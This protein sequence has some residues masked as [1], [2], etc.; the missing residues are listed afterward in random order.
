LL[1]NGWYEDRQSAWLR[2]GASQIHQ[3]L[4]NPWNWELTSLAQSIHWIV[5]EKRKM[6]FYAR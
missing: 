5:K 6:N 3:V 4:L 2:T 1:E